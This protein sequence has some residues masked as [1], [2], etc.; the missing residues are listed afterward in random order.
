MLSHYSTNIYVLGT[1]LGTGETT[2]ISASPI[3]PSLICQLYLSKAET[4]KKKNLPDYSKTEVI[5]HC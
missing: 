2:N 3:K 5:L 1:V 4:E